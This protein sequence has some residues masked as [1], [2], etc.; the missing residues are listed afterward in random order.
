MLTNAAIAGTAL[1]VYIAVLVLQLNPH[2]SLSGFPSLVLTLVVAYGLNAAVVFYVLIVIQQVLSAEPIS[3]GWISFRVLVWLCAVAAMAGAGLT[4]VNLWGFGPV[5][6]PSTALRMTGGAV[7]VSLCAGFMLLLAAWYRWRGHQASRY[8]PPILALLLMASVAV[9]MTFRGPGTDAATARS[10]SRIP[11]GSA[12]IANGPRVTLL[13][14]E[15]ASLDI[16]APGAADGRLPNF[17]R[18]ME[19]AA[20]MHVATI[21]PTQPGT[22]WTAAATGK[23]PVKNGIRS[24]GTYWPV[25]SADAI[26]MLPDSCFAHALV[27]FR[28]LRQQLHTSEDLRA[29]TLW[30]ILSQQAVPVGIIN[31]SISQPARAVLGYQVSDEFE[32]MAGSSVDLE[33]RQG[34]WPREATAVAAAAVARASADPKGAPAV[35]VPGVSEMLAATC[36]ADRMYE[37]MAADFEQQF[38]SRLRAIRYRCLDAAGHYLLHYAVPNPFGDVSEEDVRRYDLAVGAYYAAA[39]AVIGRALAALRPGDLLIVMSGFGMDPMD[40]G[41]RLLE[42]AFGNPV[43]TG[44]HERAPDGFMFVAGSA[45]ARGRYARASIVDVVPTVLYYFGLPVGRDMDGFARTDLFKGDFTANRPI[46]FIPSYER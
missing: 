27:R 11:A 26:D 43:P 17:G 18:L 3:P 16:I 35:V 4:W 40:I 24:A 25:G 1:A 23:L 28:F 34:V 45:V 5:L 7:A 2:Y 13:L 12:E 37:Q 8:Q 21:R 33:T 22:V 6:D 10:A 36:R 14:F 31:W 9:P 41:K 42:K 46:T 32:R 44:T 29:A 30:S 19:S 38:P 15:G 20:F 39:D